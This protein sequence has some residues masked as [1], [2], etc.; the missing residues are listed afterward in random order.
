[1]SACRRVS[2]VRHGSASRP[3]SSTGAPVRSRGRED[4][5]S[6]A[7]GPASPR[8]AA[9]GGTAPAPGRPGSGRP[10]H[11]D[12]VARG[13]AGWCGDPAVVV[14][15]AAAGR[16]RRPGRARPTA[17]PLEP[18]LVVAPQP[19]LGQP[20][21]GLDQRPDGRVQGQ[22]R[23]ADVDDAEQLAGDAGRGSGAAVQYQGCWACSKC[24]AENSCTGAASASAVPIALVPTVASVQRRALD[25]AERVG[26]RRTRGRALAPQDDAVGVGDH[27]QE[28]R[29]VGDADQHR[30]ELVDR[31]APAATRR[32]RRST[33][34]KGSG[35]R[36]LC[37]VR[38]QAE[39]AA[40]ATRSARPAPAGAPA[41]GRRRGPRR[42]RARRS[43]AC[44]DRSVPADRRRSR[45]TSTSRSARCRDR[46]G[47]H[48]A[49]LSVT[50]GRSA[51]CCAHAV[52]SPECRPV[53]RRRARMTQ[54]L[55]LARADHRPAGAATGSPAFEDGA[56]R[57]RRRA[58]RRPVRRRPASGATWSPSP[59][60]SPPSRTAP[61]SP[62]CSTRPSTDSTRPASPSTSRADRGRRGDHGLVHASR[63]RS[64]A[65]AGCCGSSRRTARPRR[66]RS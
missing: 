30:P 5:A 16:A 59:G 20:D 9:R 57:P 51:V 44:C 37:G 53:G 4:P 41:G 48:A 14:D 50:A 22:R 38:V 35:S 46:P 7:G 25:E 43:R 54:T 66:G 33:S 49:T 63:P 2:G 55:A 27:H 13:D 26:L 21:R 29:G 18:L 56:A 1:M 19:R 58:G 34:A 42:A 15:H 10:G 65:A 47:A 61:A 60:T 40:P 24:S 17:Q 23:P 28:R 39:A 52:T 32:R 62:T 36:A 6:S 3:T 8:R 12:P 11:R 31:P 45:L 64:A